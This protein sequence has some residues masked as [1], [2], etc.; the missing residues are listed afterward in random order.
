M[1]YKFRG[2]STYDNDWRYG[3]YYTGLNDEENI[4]HIIRTVGKEG[5]YIEMEVNPKTVGMWTG[6]LDKK[7]KEVYSGDILGHPNP[8]CKYIVK[9]G[10]YFYEDE[11]G[12]EG[13]GFYQ[14][15]TNGKIKGTLGKSESG[16]VIGNIHDN[17]E[18][19]NNPTTD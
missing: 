7:G 13:I 17:P 6:L 5:G 4:T 11:Y 2:K 8:I 16:K 15:D 1:N 9:F 3:F 12:Y 10:Q 18:V 14:E 19:I